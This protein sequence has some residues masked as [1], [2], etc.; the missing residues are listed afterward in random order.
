MCL[1]CVWD[2]DLFPLIAINNGPLINDSLLYF[3]M[4]MQASVKNSMHFYQALI[5]A[6]INDDSGQDLIDKTDPDDADFYSNRG[7]I[8]KIQG[9]F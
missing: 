3:L 7:D 9:Y 5:Q 6:E 1:G 2:N 4:R 8:Q